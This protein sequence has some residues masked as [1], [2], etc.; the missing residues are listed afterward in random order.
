MFVIGGEVAA[1]GAS[2]ACRRCSH[3]GKPGLASNRMLPTVNQ[4]VRKRWSDCPELPLAN[5]KR[6]HRHRPRS[7]WRRQE[8]HRRRKK[9]TPMGMNGTITTRGPDGKSDVLGGLRP[10]RLRRAM[11]LMPASRV[12][13]IPVG[14]LRSNTY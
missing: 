9:T 12:F 3:S 11:N 6:R 10:V 13:G 2:C 14:S 7:R 8:L 4:R 1:I 5:V